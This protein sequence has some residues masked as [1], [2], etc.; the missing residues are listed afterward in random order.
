MYKYCI[1]IGVHV[2]FISLFFKHVLLSL[3][4]KITSNSI[5]VYLFCET[6]QTAMFLKVRAMS[7]IRQFYR[8]FGGTAWERETK[9]KGHLFPT[10]SCHS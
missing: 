4:R 2:A 6:V 9:H 7:R 8:Q 1:K 3:Q 10:A 5:M